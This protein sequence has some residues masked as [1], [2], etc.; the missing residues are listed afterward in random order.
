MEYIVTGKEMSQY[1]RNTSERLSVPSVVLMEQAAQA[2]VERMLSLC[3][4]ALPKRVLVV[5]GTG[6]NGGDGI[7][8]ARLLNQRG[9]DAEIYAPVD[10]GSRTSELYELQK[11]IYTAYQYPVR[12]EPVEASLASE[13][14]LR[15]DTDRQ[16]DVIIDAIFGT[17]LSRGVTGRW[18]D[19]I[20]D[21]N[22]MPGR[23]IAVDIASGV[24]ADTGKVPGAAFCAEDTITFSFAKL[25]QYLWPGAGCSGRISVVPIGI[26]EES[27]ME[28]R[29]RVCTFT[30]EELRLLPARRP[31]SHKGT[32]GRLL[33]IAGS[34]QMAGA[35]IFAAKAAYRMGTGLVRILTPEA[36]R[37]ILQTQ[38]PEAILSVYEDEPDEKQLRDDLAWSD[39]LVFGPGVGTGTGAG[40]ILHLLMHEAQIP[41]LLDADALNL[42]AQEPGLLAK[43]W[44]L[45]ESKPEGAASDGKGDDRPA[46]IVT[47]HLRE[48][49]RL[50]GSAVD[51]IKSQLIDTACDYAS[52][53]RVICVLKDAH[54]ITALPK[55][56]IYLNRSGNNGMATAGSGDVLS[57]IIGGL[58]AQGLTPDVAAPLGVYVHG[59]AGDAARER[60]GARYMLA[61][62]IIEGLKELNRI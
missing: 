2:F 47:P 17:G 11:K 35:A 37:V 56:G 53:N 39:A 42:L 40:N 3:A 46:M 58:L 7:A 43:R 23:K 14:A 4:A 36:N 26:T 31:D 59:L 55:G 44:S 13:S 21:M 38:V 9:F 24:L 51:E 25:G 5:C 49:S 57:G 8:I 16:Y 1:D 18:A 60:L 22:A 30:K 41:M 10:E 52:E 50:T 61:S 29:P 27:F 12:R 32:Y 6:N 54:T 62:D 20:A 48:M 33:I 28:S 19:V 15:F 34:P 45:D